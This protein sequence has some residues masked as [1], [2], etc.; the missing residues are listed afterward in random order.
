MRLKAIA[1]HNR[2][3]RLEDW[4]GLDLTGGSDCASILTAAMT[5]AAAD[6][7]VVEG[8]TTKALGGILIGTTVD[9]LAPLRGRSWGLASGTAMALKAGMT[10][11]SPIMK[12]TDIDGFHIENI[13]FKGTTRNSGNLYT[14]QAAI[15]LQLGDVDFS[16]GSVGDYACSRGTMRNVLFDGLQVGLS[17]QGWQNTFYNVSS[18]YCDIGARL[19]YQNGGNGDFYFEACGVGFKVTNT[20]VFV[21]TK[22]LE[23]AVLAAYRTGPSLID[24]SDAVTIAGYYTEG[25]A[26]A[27]P[28]LSVGSASASYPCYD[29]EIGRGIVGSPLYGAAAIALDYVKN[30]EIKTRLKGSTSLRCYSTTANTRGDKSPAPSQDYGFPFADSAAKTQSAALDLLVNPYMEGLRWGCKDAQIGGTT[31]ATISE[32]TTNIRTGSSALKVTA[33]AGQSNN[34]VTNIFDDSWV[35]SIKGRPLTLGAWVYIPSGMNMG[36]NESPNTYAPR[37]VIASNGTGGTSAASSTA[38][39]SGGWS[40]LHVML[41]AVPS[42]ATTVTLTFSPNYTLTAAVGTEYIIVDEVHLAIGDCW[43]AMYEGRIQRSP[44]AVGS[45]ENGLLSMRKTKAQATTIIADTNQTHEVGDRIIYTDAAAGEVEGKRL[46][47][48]GWKDFGVIEA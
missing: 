24:T 32:E 21:F 10:D 28:W 18:R 29:L 9:Y 42:D 25:P 44:L 14:A 22:L 27:F 39:L 17:A 38:R 8:P 45:V 15:G 20:Y 26:V 36:S 11:G 4:N 23:Q 6:G 3:V 33:V 41:S 43:E 34:Y 48:T 2:V 7:A 30:F 46:T 37:I 1:D 5:Q 40:F 19:D 16:V 47:A 12:A 31:R 13:I 35:S